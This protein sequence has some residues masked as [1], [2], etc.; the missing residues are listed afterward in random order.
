MYLAHCNFYAIHI[1]SDWGNFS[2]WSTCVAD[3]NHNDTFMIQYV[4]VT[5]LLSCVDCV[6]AFFFYSFVDSSLCVECRVCFGTKESVSRLA[7]CIRFDL[8]F[9]FRVII[10]YQRSM[11]IWMLLLGKFKWKID[12]MMIVHNW[13]A[14]AYFWF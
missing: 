8:V 13:F 6:C 7:Q 5:C 9:L 1:F 11:C 14:D 2:I 10:V 12:S 4:D 3:Y